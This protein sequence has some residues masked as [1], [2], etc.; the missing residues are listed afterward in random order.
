M[1]G[2]FEQN[3]KLIQQA[4]P[5]YA[6]GYSLVYDREVPC[7]F[8]N[9]NANPLFRGV[10]ECVKIRVLIKGDECN[11]TSLLVELT[12][13]V[14]VFMH[15][16]CIVNDNGFL[17][18]REDQNLLCEYSQFLKTL[19][20]LFNRCIAEQ[21][22]LLCAIIFITKD[23]ASLEFIEN[24]EYKMVR[25]L[26]LPLKISSPEVV[27]EQVQYRYTATLARLNLVLEQVNQK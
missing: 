13:D 2:Q 4:D 12:T 23:T 8:R 1:E 18:L 3:L 14:D 22:R 26:V 5:I 25:V 6:T 19:L 10:L 15:Y 16:T 20:V 21:G 24:L 9:H 11:L 27:R 7:E 17:R